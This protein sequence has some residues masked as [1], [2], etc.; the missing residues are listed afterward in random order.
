MLDASRY[1][2]ILK[3]RYLH[4]LIRIIL[5]FL[6]FGVMI[7]LKAQLETKDRQLWSDYF[8]TYH[9]SSKLSFGGDLGIRGFI[10]N[11]DWNQYYIRPAVTF[12][13]KYALSFTGALA[14]FHTNNKSSPN[15]NEFRAHEQIK[16]KWPDLGIIELFYRLRL[17][18]RFFNYSY[19]LQNEFNSRLRL[20][21]GMESRDFTW[22]GPRSPIYFIGTIEGFKTLGEENST[23][24]F[25]NQFRFD[26]AFGQRVNDRFRYE[27]HYIAQQSKLFRKDGSE[28][29]QK[30]LRVRFLHSVFGNEE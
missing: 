17:E 15:I 5:F 2:L 28:A 16:F 30:I 23:E 8:M 22:L 18:Q 21:F 7:P 25:I 26:L 10:S 1:M 9:K 4:V 13:S 27:I 6:F 24:T 12:R 19:E 29:L 11:Y 14:Y 3:Y 20:L